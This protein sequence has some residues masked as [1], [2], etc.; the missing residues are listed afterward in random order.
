MKIRIPYGEG[1]A[2]YLTQGK[3]YDCEPAIGLPGM[4]EFKADNGKYVF[5]GLQHSSHLGGK[6]PEVLEGEEG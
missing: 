5:M 6:A 4:V 3:V 1:V 2:P